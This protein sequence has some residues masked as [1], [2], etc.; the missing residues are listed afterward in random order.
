MYVDVFGEALVAPHVPVLA[1]R[2][3]LPV[4]AERGLD[5]VTIEF[6]PGRCHAYER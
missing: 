3:E 1:D 4:V 6:R 2:A 5:F